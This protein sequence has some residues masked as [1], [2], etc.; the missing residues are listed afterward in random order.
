MNSVKGT[1]ARAVARFVLWGGHN[2]KPSRSAGFFYFGHPMFS[3]GHP[4]MG[5]PTANM[6]WPKK[7]VHFA[8]VM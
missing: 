3:V 1:G 6:G 7:S 2:V 8:P 4:K 5:W